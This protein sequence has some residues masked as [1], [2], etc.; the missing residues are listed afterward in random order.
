MRE[1]GDDYERRAEALLLAAGLK[2]VERNWSCR[3]GEID[4]I[5]RD[6]NTLVFVEVRKR[7]SQR[8]GGAAA[9]IGSDKRGRIERAVSLYLSGLK[10]VPACRIDAV[11][12][13]AVAAPQWLKNV[14]AD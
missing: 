3:F 10:N 4:L 2:L 13:D 8:F 7:N 1:N 12:Y 5:M 9:S 14:F 11:L 6:G